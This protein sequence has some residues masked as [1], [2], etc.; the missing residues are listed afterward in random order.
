MYA[1]LPMKA[2]SERVPEK[3]FRLLHGK[4]FF[5]HIADTLK[6]TGLFTNLVIDTDSRRIEDLA[7]ERYGEWVVII[8]RPK[9]LQGDY[10]PMNAVIAHDIKVLGHDNDFMQTHS[11]NPFLRAE[12]IL[13]A[14]AMY[15]EG[16]ESGGFDS[17]F[18]VNSIKTRLYDKDLRPLNHNPAILGRTQD[19]DV[20]YEENSNFYFF[21]GE[22]FLRHSHRIGRRLRVFAMNRNSIESLDVDDLSDWE[23]AEVLLKAGMTTF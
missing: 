16:K 10:V 12:T 11:T 13:S 9:E 6:T 3:N 21:S 4:P 2:H 18:A 17:L 15:R 5:F 1:L 7:K 8:Q 19:L 14:A 20:I 23:F 22:S